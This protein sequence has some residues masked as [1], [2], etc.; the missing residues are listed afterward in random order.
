MDLYLDMSVTDRCDR[1]CAHCGCNSRPDGTVFLPLDTARALFSEIATMDFRYVKLCIS[2]GGEPLMHSG[3]AGI[4]DEAYKALGKRLDLLVVTS[5]CLDQASGEKE[6]IRELARKHRQRLKFLLSFNLYNKSFPERLQTTLD[7]LLQER[8]IWTEIKLCFSL[9]NFVET[10]CR[11]YDTL[12]DFGISSGVDV[13]HLMVDIG[14]R[15]FRP[16]HYLSKLW[17]PRRARQLTG[18][19]LQSTCFYILDGNKG[20]ML[21]SVMPFS[22][23]QRG[24]A[25]YLNQR[26]WYMPGCRFLFRFPRQGVVNLFIDHN[27]RILPDCDCI[28]KAE[29]MSFGK[30][31]KISLKDALEV[32]E[33]LG[34]FL[35]R[36]IIGDKRQFG[37]W[38][39]CEIC[40]GYKRQ[41]NKT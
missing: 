29:I 35:T 24:R 39:L 18:L 36:S 20:K 32:K 3:L 23:H 25:Q 34:H 30:V 19:S 17:S 12:N 1:G 14:D 28:H 15:F 16:Q 40:T 21:L 31:G 8:M 27:A 7:L 6:I 41:Y 2:G 13:R 11:L 26:A 22:L 9:D 10:Y 4:C 37:D 33:D 38:D 5:G